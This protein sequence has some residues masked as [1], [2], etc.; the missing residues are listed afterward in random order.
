MPCGQIELA[1]RR[2]ESELT[3]WAIFKGRLNMATGDD[4]ALELGV[5]SRLYAGDSIPDET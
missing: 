4:W 2:S 3:L 5:E 1:E